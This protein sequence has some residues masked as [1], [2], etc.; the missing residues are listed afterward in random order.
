M[1]VV[2]N[3]DEVHT[4]LTLVT[5]QVLDHVELSP[6]GKEAIRAWRRDRNLGSKE[7]DGFAEVMN[8]AIGTLID[9]NTTRM[10]RRRGGQ[11]VRAV[12]GTRS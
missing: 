1:N 8:R 4:V 7:L 10:L 12:E 5:S 2:L 11:R 9:E 6:E 3:V